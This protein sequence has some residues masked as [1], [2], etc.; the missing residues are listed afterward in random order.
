MDQPQETSL[1]NLWHIYWRGRMVDTLE[2]LEIPIILKSEMLQVSQ[3][4]PL[5]FEVFKLESYFSPVTALVGGVLLRVIQT[6]HL[7]DSSQMLL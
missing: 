5:D 2:P 7:A 3:L 1:L 4:F 6:V